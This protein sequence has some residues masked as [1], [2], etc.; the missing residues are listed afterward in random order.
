LSLGAAAELLEASKKLSDEERAA[1]GVYPEIV[2]GAFAR[3]S[4]E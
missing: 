3:Y 4:A 1:V 2:V